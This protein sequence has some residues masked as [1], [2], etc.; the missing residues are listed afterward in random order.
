MESSQ[1]LNQTQPESWGGKMSEAVASSNIFKWTRGTFIFELHWVGSAIQFVSCA[2]LR[3][4]LTR[5]TTELTVEAADGLI[6]LEK[7][8]TQD[9]Q[10]AAGHA[11]GPCGLYGVGKVLTHDGPIALT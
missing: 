10:L 5:L 3:T 2:R 11:Q 9:L 1:E 6:A 8:P 4:Q 7:C